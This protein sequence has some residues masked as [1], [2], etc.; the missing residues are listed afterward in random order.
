MIQAGEGCGGDGEGG[1]GEMWEN[2]SVVPPFPWLTRYDSRAVTSSSSKISVN[3]PAYVHEH[4][5]AS[6]V[7]DEART[8]CRGKGSSQPSVSLDIDGQEGFSRI[9]RSCWLKTVGLWVGPSRQVR[10]ERG[11]N[12]LIDGRQSSNLKSDEEE[13]ERKK[14]RERETEQEG[15]Q[16][17]GREIAVEPRRLGEGR[18]V[19]ADRAERQ[20]EG[21][22]EGEGEGPAGEMQAE[23]SLRR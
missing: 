9:G 17:G 22:G 13:E 11:M 2:G 6:R 21:E 15:R 12:W 7:I 20:R 19:M 10:E 18:L 1:E 5:P 8:D 3:R 16:P 14:K 4:P 23:R